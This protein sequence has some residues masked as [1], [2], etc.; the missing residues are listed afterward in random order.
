MLVNLLQI[1][2]TGLI[3]Y[4]ERPCDVN[5][6]LLRLTLTLLL[7]SQ[8]A[9]SFC[10]PLS[11]VT[12]YTI[13]SLLKPPPTV[14]LITFV[15]G[16]IH[17]CFPLFNIRSLQTLIS[18]V[19]YLNMSDS[20][21]MFFYQ[22]ILHVLAYAFCFIFC[23]FCVFNWYSLCNS[24]RL[25]YWIKGYLLTY[26]LTYLVQWPCTCATCGMMWRSGSGMG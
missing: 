24:M 2:K 6:Y 15:R 22:F 14:I 23:V 21:L 25:S 20:Y 9:N 26:L 13:F 1:T 12:V 7:T 18:I 16:N 5:W 8:I 3:L 4:Q 10:R 11:Q 17:T 19:V